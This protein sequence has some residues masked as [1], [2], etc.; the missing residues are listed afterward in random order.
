MKNCK[1]N[2]TVEEILEKLRTDDRWV[3]RGLLAL[4]NNQ[5]YDEV[6]DRSTHLL[7]KVGFNAFDADFLT[8]MVERYKDGKYFTEKQMMVIRKR[9]LKYSKQLTKI[10]NEK[11]RNS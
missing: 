9:I 8:G 6:K 10:A 4:Y 5:S 11:A 1:K 3:I 2:W 7:N